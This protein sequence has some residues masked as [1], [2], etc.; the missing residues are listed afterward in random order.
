MSSEWKDIGLAVLVG[1][2]VGWVV[3]FLKPKQI[4][5]AVIAS[6]S[7]I[8]HGGEKCARTVG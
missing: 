3:G 1:S 6:K 4:A 8:V 5:N 7:G 2:F